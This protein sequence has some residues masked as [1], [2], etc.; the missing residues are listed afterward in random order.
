MPKL[1][2]SCF[3]SSCGCGPGASWPRSTYTQCKKNDSTF[4]RAGSRS[5]S[6]EPFGAR[7]VI[8]A[9]SRH[10]WWNAEDTSA[11]AIIELQPALDTETIFETLFG[12]ARDGKTNAKGMPGL[13]QLAVLS[14]ASDGY[15]AGPPIWLQRLALRVLAF[16]GRIAGYRERYAEYGK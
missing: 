5:S 8:P 16:I 6:T 11:L 12:L 2:E 1:V 10:S 9:G 15:V 7:V 4:A 14:V 13:L 3:G